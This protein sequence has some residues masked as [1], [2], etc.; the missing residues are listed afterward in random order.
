MQLLGIE[1]EVG[2]FDEL[3][4]EQN[5]GKKLEIVDGNIIAVNYE[6]TEQEKK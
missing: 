6:P 4:C 3:I 2:K 5:K 1:V